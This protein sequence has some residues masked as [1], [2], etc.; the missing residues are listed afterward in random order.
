MCVVSSSQHAS[1]LSEVSGLLSIHLF[2]LQRQ[3]EIA[4]EHSLMQKV[5]AVIGAGWSIQGG[6][7][8]ELQTSVGLTV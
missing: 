8:A 4:E 6:P 1:D 3:E 2:A 5:A 7:N